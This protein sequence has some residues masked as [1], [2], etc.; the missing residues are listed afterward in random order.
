MERGEVP[1][2]NALED[3]VKGAPPSHWFDGDDQ[4]PTS[5]SSREQENRSCGM[6]RL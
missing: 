3:R 2:V 5:I 4:T 1:F 6:T